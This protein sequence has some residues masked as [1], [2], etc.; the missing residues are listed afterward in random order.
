MH[1]SIAAALGAGALAVAANLHKWMA[2][3]SYRPSI[4]IALVAWPLLTLVPAFFVAII[5][6]A[7][8]N[9]CIHT[10]SLEYSSPLIR[11]R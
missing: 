6:A 2:G 1:A 3:S 9:H 4:A 7:V 5:V 11:L 10:S 8:L